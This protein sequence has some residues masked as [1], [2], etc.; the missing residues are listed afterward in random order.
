MDDEDRWDFYFTM[1]DGS[2]G[3]IFFN[4]SLRSRAPVPGA[5]SCVYVRL[6]MRQARPDGLSSS[7]EF[8]VLSAIDDALASELCQQLGAIYAGRATYAGLRDL[9]YYAAAGDVVAAAA[10]KVMRGFP[11]YKCEVGVRPDGDWKTYFEYLLPTPRD[12]QRMGNRDVCESLE[13]HGDPLLEAREID[14]WAYFATAASRDAF[15]DRVTPLG[16][17]VR[18]LSGPDQEREAS[19]QY[20]AQIFREDVPT[21]DEINEVTLELFDIAAAAGGTYDGWESVVLKSK[22]TTH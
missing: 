18:H 1:I 19:S 3:S 12:R 8:D 2:S 21:L 14:H 16:Y 9:F 17:H 4:D 11:D 22:D 5:S 6:F 20:C 10:T 13:Q 15:V 7:E